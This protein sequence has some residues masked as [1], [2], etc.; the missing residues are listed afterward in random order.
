MSK[1]HPNLDLEMIYASL[2]TKEMFVFEKDGEWKDEGVYHD[3]LSLDKTYHER[4]WY[5][6]FSPHNF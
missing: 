1:P 3:G 4:N 6:E 5:D 2:A